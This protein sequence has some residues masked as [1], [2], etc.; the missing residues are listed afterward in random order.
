MARQVVLF[1]SLSR[2]F[3]CCRRRSS[4]D[5][6]DDFSALR[7]RICLHDF[8]GEACNASKIKDNQVRD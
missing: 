8:C 4:A 1:E 2:R 5:R 6:R 7:V 3:G